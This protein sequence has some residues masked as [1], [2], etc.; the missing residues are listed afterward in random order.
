MSLDQELFVSCNKDCGAGCPLVAVVENGVI[1]SIRDNPLRGTYM[2]GCAKGYRMHRLLD[3]PDRLRYPL[4]RTGARGSKEFKRISWDE[5]LDRAGE[6][7]SGNTVMRL[8]GSGACRGLVHN[9]ARLTTRF[10]SG[11]PFYIDTYGSY[12]SEAADY[13]KPLLFGRSDIGIDIRTLVD[14]KFLL[15]LGFH[16][17]DTRF[18]CETEAV[19]KELSERGVPAVVVDPRRTGTVD[20]CNASWIP[21]KPGSDAVLLTAL[22]YEVLTKKG[23]GQLPLTEGYRTIT[24]WVLGEHDGVQR[25]PGWAAFLCGIP[26]QQIIELARKLMDHSP[27]ALLPGLSVQR[28]LGGEEAD[29]MGLVLQLALG[30]VG[31]RGGSAGCGQWN[32][33]PKVPVGGVPGNLQGHNKPFHVPV[34]RWADWVLEHPGSVGCLYNVGGNFLGQSSNTASVTR[35]LDAVEVIITHEQMLTPTARYSDIIFPVSMFLERRDLCTANNGLLLY[36]EQAVKAPPEVRHDYDI[37]RE[38]SRRLGFEELFSEGRSADQWVDYLMKQADASV[39]NTCMRQG[40]WESPHRE[41]GWVGLA[42]A[43]KGGTLPTPSGKIELTPASYHEATGSPVPRLL[44]PSPGVT[45]PLMLITP[46]ARHRINSHGHELGLSSDDR[47]QM[48]PADAVS[49]GIEDGSRVKVLN[50][51]GCFVAEVHLTHTIMA[52]TVSKLQG[53]WVL[54]DDQKGRVRTNDSVNMVS[55]SEPTMPSHGSRTHSISVEVCAY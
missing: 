30:N 5:A 10:L 40:Y 43:L 25:S 31:V 48:N 41:K 4:L 9:T 51:I 3:H 38:L 33:Q 34:Y 23:Y 46:H 55:S 27:S 45:R 24:S 20:L 54:L 28:T 39:K 17:L 37:F 29:R 2:R 14:T 12:S 15:L 1:Q 21:I 53:T 16:P 22:T 11:L 6:A 26:E 35:A 8:G 32:Y 19:L 36:S 44:Y 47:L 50:D 13:M 7:I 18:G 42:D 49:R 52:G